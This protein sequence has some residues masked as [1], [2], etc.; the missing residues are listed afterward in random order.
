L[1]KRLKKPHLIKK[2]QQKCASLGACERNRQRASTPTTSCANLYL[3]VRVR[4]I[5]KQQSKQQKQFP[6]AGVRQI[7]K[8]NNNTN[9]KEQRTKQAPKK[10]KET[11][12]GILIPIENE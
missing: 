4:F 8:S 10:V 9:N 3:Y 11:T 12:K 2:N 5:H 1:A 6:A 7:G